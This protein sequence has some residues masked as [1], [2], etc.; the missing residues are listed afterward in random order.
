MA[1][2]K[3]PIGDWSNDG[4]GKCQY[5]IATTPLTVDH[6]REVHFA[7]PAI[8]GFDIGSICNE[9]GESSISPEILAKIAKV[10][11]AWSEELEG[12]ESLFILWISLLNKIDP[13]LMLTPV[14]ED[15]EDIHF[16]GFDAKN[17]HLNTPGYGLFE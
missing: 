16:C 4:H 13:Y 6:V 3:F 2:I 1:R 11:P 12:P 7:A 9:Y 10:L 17:R 14:V 15:A 8:L 5:F